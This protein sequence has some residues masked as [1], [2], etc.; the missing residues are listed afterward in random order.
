MAINYYIFIN[1]CNQKT[2][3]ETINKKNYNVIEIEDDTVL[4]HIMFAYKDCHIFLKI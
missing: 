3:R 1:Q 2:H 4:K